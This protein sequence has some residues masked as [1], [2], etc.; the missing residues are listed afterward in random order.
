MATQ[1]TLPAPAKINLFLHIVGRR[2]DGYH[3]LESAMAMVAFGD[4]ISLTLRT[5]GVI[6]MASPTPGVNPE[7]DLCVRAARALQQ[8]TACTLGVTI[9]IVK[10]IP[11]GA[12][13]GGGSSD[14]ATV[15]LGLNRLWNLQRP[16]SELQQIGLTLGADVP[17]FIFGRS[18][19]ARG[20]GEDLE[21]VSIPAA[22][23]WIAKPSAHAS[24]PLIFSQGDLK[25]DS[26]PLDAS[27]IALAG[28]RNDMQPVAERLFPE[29]AQ[30][31]MALGEPARMS[32]SGAAVF[33]L[34]SSALRSLDALVWRVNT[35][36]LARHPLYAFA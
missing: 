31:R 13:L 23:I 7:D 9:R 21:P 14:A 2:S 33:R 35:R 18:A 30:L 8:A 36:I 27:V 12:G 24:T 16:R 34:G 20:V 5:D 29:I 15:L 1:L 17:F 32:G 25:R 22:Q 26:P 6:E 11:M 10:R 4:T 28:G 3:L 19:L